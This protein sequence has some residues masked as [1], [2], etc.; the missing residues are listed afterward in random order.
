M[1][2]LG[3]WVVDQVVEAAPVLEVG[4]V[5][6]SLEEAVVDSLE[7]E[8]PVEAVSLEE[9]DPVGADFP[10]EVLVEAGLGP[11]EAVEVD[12]LEA[13]VEAAVVAAFLEAVVVVAAAVA[14]G[15]AVV[16]DL[17]VVGNFNYIYISDDLPAPPSYVPI[18]GF[19]D[20]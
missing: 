17:A 19:K 2:S 20:A 8:D 3:V 5:V 11:A 1:A 4:A 14:Q 12:F 13:V 9:E 7:E 15:L 6:D 16:V 18:C 10:G